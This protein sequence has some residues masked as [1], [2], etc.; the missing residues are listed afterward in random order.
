M[1]RKRKE[2]EERATKRRCLLAAAITT[3]SSAS[4]AGDYRSQQANFQATC[5]PS[6]KINHNQIE[7]NKK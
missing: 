4:F 5:P 6:R 3:G 1:K 2:E 7:C